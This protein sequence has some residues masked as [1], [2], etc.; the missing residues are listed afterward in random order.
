M[1]I[2]GNAF[3]KNESSYHQTNMINSY[4][5][6]YIRRGAKEDARC[7]RLPYIRKGEE[8][9]AE[10]KHPNDRTHRHRNKERQASHQEQLIPQ[11]PFSSRMQVFGGDNPARCTC[12]SSALSR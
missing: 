12:I 11:G 9:E 7:S 1:F 2:Y 6:S 10:N 5:G 8:E 3:R 4:V